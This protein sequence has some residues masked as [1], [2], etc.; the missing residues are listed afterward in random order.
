M[1]LKFYA[2]FKQGTEGP[3]KMR[4]PAFWD[5]VGRAKYD[6]WKRLGEMPKEKAMKE[7]VEELGKIVETMSYTQNVADFYGAI[8]ELD[9]IKVEDLELIAPTVI[10]THK[11]DSNSP[12]RQL[13]TEKTA[14][15]IPNG[16]INQNG[17]TYSD[18]NNSESSDDEYIDTVE[19]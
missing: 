14:A 19:V 6:A 1:M 17:S 7:Y 10:K 15:D 13:A 18:S 2:Y 4:R 8:S 3:C 5:V 16:F 11:E 9:N 12:L